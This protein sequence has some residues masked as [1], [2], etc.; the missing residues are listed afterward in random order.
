MDF[1]ITGLVI[2]LGI[3]SVRLVGLRTP[4]MAVLG[5]GPYAIV[6]SLVSAV[7]LALIVY[8]HILAHPSEAIWAPP[9]WTRTLALVAIPSAIILIV[10]AYLPGHIRS[11]V[12]HPMT[13]GIF[14]WAGVHF[15]A[16][17]NIA[18]MVLFGS[19]AVWA[20]LTLI[21]AYARGGS[22]ESAGRWWA[23]IASIVIGL[24]LAGLVA[25]F[26]MDLFGVAVFEFASDP[27]APG[28]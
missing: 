26:H 22:F 23:D 27:Y 6:Y 20:F 16:N 21:S 9:E 4:L 19:F 17:G 18:S 1:L 11:F 5:P 7:G 10:S 8:G 3:H 2:F 24:A 13:L 14:L 12:R 28:I 15:L 25:W